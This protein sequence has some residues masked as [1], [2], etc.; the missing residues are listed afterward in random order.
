MK[1]LAILQKTQE[2][3]ATIEI[4]LAS[5]TGYYQ[6]L[7]GLVGF[8]PMS[9]VQLSTGNAY[10]LSGQ[11]RTLTYAG[12]P[13]YNQHNGVVPYIDLDGTGDW[14]TRPDEADLDIIGNEAIYASA[15]RG[16]TMGGWFWLDAIAA[17]SG[18]MTKDNGSTQRSYSLFADPTN[19]RL[20]A[21]FIGASASTVLLNGVFTSL[22]RWVFCVARW[23]PSTS[24]K[25]WANIDGQLSTNINTTSI[26]ATL[27][28]STTPLYVGAVNALLPMNGRA[29]M[30]FLCANNL[31]DALINHLFNV[32]RPYYGV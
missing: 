14:L 21:S 7:P 8:W 12:N 4:G 22:N 16:V 9:S 11:G 24:V 3:E 20:A 25:V 13:T 2:Q 23:I 27:N 5:M 30:C 32:T 28:N 26:I 29:S 15:V 17:I 19:T 18:L 1:E 6:Q 31:S 10:D